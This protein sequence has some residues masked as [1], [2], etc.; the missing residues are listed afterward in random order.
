[1]EKEDAQGGEE[2]STKGRKEGQWRDYMES[3]RIAL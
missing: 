2:I 3:S 1:M